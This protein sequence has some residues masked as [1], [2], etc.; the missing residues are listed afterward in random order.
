[1]EKKECRKKKV[2][3]GLALGSGSALGLAHIGVLK[4][5][6]RNNIFPD[7]LAGTSMGAVIAALYAAGNT[8]EEIEHMAKTTNWHEIIDFTIPKSG[9]L[10]GHL[11][12]LRLRKLLKNKKFHD[13]KIPLQIVAY[14]IDLE[15]SAIFSQGDL[16]R[17][18]RASISI[19]GIFNPVKINNYH[20]I[21]GGVSYPT[22]FEIVKKM[23]AE[24]IIAVDLYVGKEKTTHGPIVKERDFFK[25]IQKTFVVQEL[26]NIKNYLIPTRWPGF[27]RKVLNWLFDKLLFPA[28]LLKIMAKRELPQIT[29][30]VYKTY[31]ILLENLAREKIKS[32]VID[33]KITPKFDGLDW[34]S[35]NQVEKLIKSGELA[36]ERALPELRRKLGN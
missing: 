9:L 6:H 26:L 29:H 33:V 19:P 1:M 5:L 20:Y 4:V 30:V 18:L 16:A 32:Q 3:I 11:I 23:G 34:E 14:N 7:Y 27:L 13:L 2:K 21:D 25:E 31:M 8:P 12:E 36:A 24:K 22:P 15:E 17:A 35:F 28:R 10:Q